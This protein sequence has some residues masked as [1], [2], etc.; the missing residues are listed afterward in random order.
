MSAI[1]GL[2]TPIA[3]ATIWRGSGE[4]FHG[5]AT[6]TRLAVIDCTYTSNTVLQSDAAGREFSPAFAV[7]TKSNE[8][9]EGDLILIGV[10]N[11]ATPPAEA[12]EVRRIATAASMFGTPDY[13]IFV[14]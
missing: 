12:K 4:D 11:S 14:G 1:R 3:K 7:F 5:N 9:R 2:F 10:S 13:D 6:Y 8:V